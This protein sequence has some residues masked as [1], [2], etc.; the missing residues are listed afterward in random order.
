[1]K[2]LR[3]TSVPPPPPKL[4]AVV[5]PGVSVTRLIGI[6]HVERQFVDA[7]L[8]DHAADVGGPRFQQ[9]VRGDVHLFLDAAGLEHEIDAR[10]LL[11]H[12]HEPV[13]HGR[14]EALELRGHGVGTRR[15]RGDAV[16][17]VGVADA[18]SHDAGVA[19][20]RR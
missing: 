6:A 5:T 18:R 9:R 19:I 3:P 16:V 2:K 14:R 8:G 1:M 7:P 13:A 4:A 17:T 15:E 10:R 12:E 20:G 11:V